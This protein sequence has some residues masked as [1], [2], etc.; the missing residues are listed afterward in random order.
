MRELDDFHRKIGRHFDAYYSSFRLN[1]EC[2]GGWMKRRK[3]LS[4]KIKSYD[5]FQR[6]K[7]GV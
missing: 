2:F 4:N 3:E 6:D 5:L 1:A 7:F